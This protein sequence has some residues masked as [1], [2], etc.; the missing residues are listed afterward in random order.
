MT[1]SENAEL[2]NRLRQMAELL[3]VQQA[4]GFRVSAYRR[5]ADTLE[6]LSTPVSE[7]LATKGTSGL[8][9]L[10]A[11]GRGIAA[12]IVEILETGSWAA[13]DRLT[14]ELDPEQLFQTLPGV[15]PDLARRIH[16][17][18][19]VDTLEALEL[20]ALDG[21]LEALHGVGA[22]RTAAIRAVVREHLDRRRFRGTTRGAMPPV[23]LLLDVDREYREKA[24]AG[25]LQKIA[26]KRF[27]PEGRA[28]LPVLHTTRKNWSFTALFSNTQRAHDLAKTG[29]WVVIYGHEPDGQETQCTVVTE[30]RGP[31][32]GRRV[33]RGQ[34]GECLTYYAETTK[35]GASGRP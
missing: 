6:S 10:P 2:A 23:S 30:Y 33:V 28:W 29:D 18:L 21:R 15:G 7:L 35:N 26:P 27:N 4:D 8:V 24:A 32:A 22:K 5:A 19:H 34:T 14:G 17:E 9:E 20:A 31:L 16:D 12:A 13:L 25:K 3:S 1:T 11:I